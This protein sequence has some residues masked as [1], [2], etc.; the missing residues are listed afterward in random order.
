MKL[1]MQP[2]HVISEEP[3]KWHIQLQHILEVI[4]FLKHA[5]FEFY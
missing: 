4:A 2:P 1:G 3:T 5:I